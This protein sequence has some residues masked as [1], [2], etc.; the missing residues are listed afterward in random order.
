MPT[1]PPFEASVPQAPGRRIKVII[2]YYNRQ[3]LVYWVKALS[4]EAENG[5]F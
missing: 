1:N 3:D 4:L 2:C 5:S